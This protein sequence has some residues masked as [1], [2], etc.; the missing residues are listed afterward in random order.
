MKTLKEK[1]INWWNGVKKGFNSELEPT[2]QIVRSEI[3]IT[4]S[5]YN[6]N[7]YPLEFIVIV[8]GGGSIYIGI[9][10]LNQFSSF[11]LPLG[12]LCLIFFFG[13]GLFCVYISI[14]TIIRKNYVKNIKN[15]NHKKKYLRLKFEH[16][17]KTINYDKNKR[18]IIDIQIVPPNRK[19]ND[20]VVN[21]VTLIQYKDP[22]DPFSNTKFGYEKTFEVSDS[23]L[24]DLIN[25]Q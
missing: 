1:I 20:W 8:M 3:K 11:Q 22:W 5:I 25:Q 14:N 23:E 15:L 9:V 13:L 18:K 17:F 24:D 19:E 2:D 21:S 6:S 7:L 16:L 12:V 10:I 4:D